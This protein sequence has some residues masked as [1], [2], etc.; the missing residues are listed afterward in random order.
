MSSPPPT[1]VMRWDEVGAAA[2]ALAAAVHADGYR[3]EIILAVARGGLIP[4]A[5]VA[6]AL[7]VKN[8][9][10]MNVEFYTDVDQRLDSPRWCSRRSPSSWTW[11]TP[12]S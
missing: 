9:Y 6:Y 4:A 12:T 1:E 2:R 8:T 7:G 10:T 5:A 3:P 11:A